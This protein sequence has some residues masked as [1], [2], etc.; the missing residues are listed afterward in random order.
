MFDET[1]L[2]GTVQDLVLML[3]KC[4]DALVFQDTDHTGTHIYHFLIL[5]AHAFFLDT[6]PDQS[7]RRIIEETQQQV[8]GF[9]IGQDLQFVGI[10]NVHDLVADIVGGFHQIDQ[11]IACAAQGFTWSILADH[12]QFIDDFLEDGL[13]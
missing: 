2:E 9:L 4:F 5:V 6:L 11:R 3:H 13:F 12:A 1:A 7:F 10:F 8:F